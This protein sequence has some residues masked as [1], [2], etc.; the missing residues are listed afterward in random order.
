MKLTDFPLYSEVKEEYL[1]LRKIGKG[2][3]DVLKEMQVSYADELQ[4]GA[5]DDALLFWIGL[6]DAQYSL[7]ELEEEVALCGLRA[8]DALNTSEHSVSSRELT[9]RKERYALAPMPE[10]K[11]PKPRAKFRCNWS[12]GDTFAFYLSG[13]DAQA[14]GI[15]ENAILFR[16]VGEINFDRGH[17]VPLVTLTLWDEN[18][19]PR[20]S[21][22]FESKP[23]LLLR[24]TKL[25]TH[26]RKDHVGILQF[27]SKR[28]LNKLNLTFIGNYPNIPYPA[29]QTAY[30]LGGQYPMIL[31]DMAAEKCYMFVQQNH[32]NLHN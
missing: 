18:I 1:E 3:A 10:R 16:K 25:L 28:Q 20:N 23:V 15:S 6:A 27:T 14:A 7:K 13:P 5:E 4:L 2:R 22:E 9:C 29:E 32:S 30:D 21:E 8:L 19:L 31:P 24:S 11:T 26:I 17:I 12:I